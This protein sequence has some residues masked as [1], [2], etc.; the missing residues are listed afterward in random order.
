[1]ITKEVN[2]ILFWVIDTMTDKGKDLIRDKM[3]FLYSPKWSSYPFLLPVLKDTVTKV[4]LL[5]EATAMQKGLTAWVITIMWTSQTEASEPQLVRQAAGH[6]RANGGSADQGLCSRQGDEWWLQSKCQNYK[7][8][9]TLTQSLFTFS[10]RIS[11]PT[12]V[13]VRGSQ[14]HDELV[15]TASACAQKHTPQES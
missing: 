15:I 1:M 5:V 7:F 9:P 3:F 8:P 2:K 6:L 10:H 4:W 12:N 14:R 13:S 11:P